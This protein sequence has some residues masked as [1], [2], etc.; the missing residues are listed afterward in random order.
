MTI[1]SSDPFATPEDAK[2][3]VRRLRGRLPAPVTLWTANDTDGRP[4][5]LTVSS[6]VVADGDPGRVLGVLDEESTLWEALRQ[7]GRFAVIPLRES[8]GQLADSFAGLLPAPGGPFVGRHWLDTEFGPV[9]D[10]AAAWAGCS[11]DN[12]RPMGWGLLV[13]AVIDHVEVAAG[14]DDGPLIHYRGRYAGRL[15]PASA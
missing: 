8:D 3:A 7:T 13:E 14:G 9:L 5:G 2:S 12:A 4:V 1:H 15:P 10:G 11:L 6:I